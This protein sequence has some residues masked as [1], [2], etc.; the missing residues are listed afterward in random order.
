MS[1]F[2]RY[3]FS[4]TVNRLE[5]MLPNKPRGDLPVGSFAG[6]ELACGAG[7]PRA[8]PSIDDDAA[9]T[10]KAQLFTLNIWW[11]TPRFIGRS[12]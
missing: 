5:P 7:S 10:P 1:F 3:H 8:A 4:I 12:Y 11:L 9:K 2:L 6:V